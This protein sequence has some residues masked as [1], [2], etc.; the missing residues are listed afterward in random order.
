MMT[1]LLLADD[2]P[3]VRQGIR[4]LLEGEQN[5]RV[6]GEVEDGLS[7]LETIERSQPQVAI[8][9]VIMP[10]ITGLE[11]TRRIKERGLKTKVIIV[12]MYSD[13]M[14]VTEALRSGAFGYVTKDSPPGTLL[15]A[16]AEVSQ[17]RRYLCQ[18][19]AERAVQMYIQRAENEPEDPYEGL[20]TR[21][22]EV[23][24]LA[25]QGY[26]NIEMAERMSISHRTVEV[27]RGNM[28]RKL[29]LNNQ[30]DLI[31]YAVKRGLINLEG[32]A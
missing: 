31:R 19:L 25:A 8:L 18:S 22:R 7:A 13:E 16:I 30:L 3:L 2:H 9:D 17:G 11:V 29:G 20:T 14:Y 5:I 15:E 4:S 23:L 12:S 28:M 32:P 24:F 26:S 21:E 6:I 27:H 10:G 1:T